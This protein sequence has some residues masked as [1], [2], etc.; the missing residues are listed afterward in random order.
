MIL[1][2]VLLFLITGTIFSAD[3]NIYIFSL[4]IGC[5]LVVFNEWLKYGKNFI[6]SPLSFFT[7][8]YLYIYISGSIQA[9]P[10]SETRFLYISS[11][12]GFLIGWMFTKHRLNFLNII[13]PI[14]KLSLRLGLVL[15][16]ILSYIG[17][18]HVPS[19]SYLT[20]I[21]LHL[22][23]S[24]HLMNERIR[25]LK[26]FN[27]LLTI[28][29]SFLL[30]KIVVLRY[31]IILIFIKEFKGKLNFYK[32][33]VYTFVSL[34]VF[35]AFNLRRYNLEGNS[36]YINLSLLQIIEPSNF[37]RILTSGSDYIKTINTLVTSDLMEIYQF[38][39]TYISGFLKF[40]PNKLFFLRPPSGN[41]IINLILDKNYTYNSSTT[42]AT[43]V[44]E[45]YINFGYFSII[46]AFIIGVSQ[47]LLW[48]TLTQIQTKYLPL[49]LSFFYSMQFSL[50]RD[51]FNIAFGTF[52]IYT[53]G[54]SLIISKNSKT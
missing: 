40:F 26:V 51:D 20:L 12:F 37:L 36:S 29:F 4:V 52:L 27:I 17:L 33:V 38:G 42:A 54:L 48:N 47:K 22:I 15:L 50:V 14:K 30:G 43:F 11:Y 31:L 24:I 9:T 25:I 18:Y 32:I 1:F 34:I 49:Y 46:G 19:I 13:L 16:F 10:Y 53:L 6:L 7:V 23:S 35:V 5:F 2:L 8:S 21:L 44:G 45:L 3:P 39:S 28:T 41:A